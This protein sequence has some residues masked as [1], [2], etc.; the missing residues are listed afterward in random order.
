ML[1]YGLI[2]WD[3]HL[4]NYQKRVITYLHGLANIKDP[5][6]IRW[7]GVNFKHIKINYTNAK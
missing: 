5:E 3:T 4:I 2:L 6:E 7:Q 1:L